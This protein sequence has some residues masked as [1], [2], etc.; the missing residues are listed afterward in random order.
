M[1]DG[2][3]C[4]FAP[5]ADSNFKQEIA[6]GFDSR[7]WEMYVACTILDEGIPIS[8]PNSKGGP[9]FR[10]VT[11]KGTIFIE[12][13]APKPGDSDKP[14]SVPKRK[15]NTLEG[16]PE[17]EILLRYCS[18]IQTKYDSYKRYLECGVVGSKDA[19]VIAVNGCKIEQAFIEFH[20]PRILK[21][22]LPIGDMQL[23]IEPITKSVIDQRHKYKPA[24]KKQ[25]GSEVKTD[26]F[27]NPE[28]SGVSGIIYSWVNYAN[29]D[30]N[31]DHWFFIHN[32]LANNQIP[33]GFLRIGYEYY[34]YE[35][36]TKLRIKDWRKSR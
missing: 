7:F 12:A 10:I 27:L 25:S 4:K 14:D 26:L 15:M 2:Y 30:P 34:P 32:P 9:D 21:A 19:Y 16:L 8:K 31:K 1:I 29:S 36:E 33:T 28:Y 11:D 6:R 5:Y 24:I 22:V 18:A 23:T 13:V 35:K 3:W 17:D 20:V